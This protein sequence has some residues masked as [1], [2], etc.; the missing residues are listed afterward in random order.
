MGREE[1]EAGEEGEPESEGV[2][3]Q[4]LKPLSKIIRWESGQELQ[5]RWGGVASGAEV[6]RS[7]AKLCASRMRTECLNI[8]PKEG[9]FRPP[10][11]GKHS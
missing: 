10:C 1:E 7:S 6:C 11:L 2:N 5:G 8:Q 3:S 4:K 9:S